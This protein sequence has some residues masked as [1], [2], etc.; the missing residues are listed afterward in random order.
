MAS[1]VSNHIAGWITDH[2]RGHLGLFP[3]LVLNVIALR[4]L[5]NL[6]SDAT[7]DT[8]A[9]WPLSIGV[10]FSLCSFAILVWQIRGGLRS[11]AEAGVGRDLIGWAGYAILLWAVAMF[12][13]TTLDHIAARFTP[14]GYL[15]QTVKNLTVLDGQI[16]LT[17]EISHQTF[18]Q[19][20]QTVATTNAISV[21]LDSP[22]GS[23]FAAR[24]VAKIVQEQSINT[25]S[26]TLCA[27]ACTLIF[28]AGAQRTLGPNGSL[29]FHSYS[30]NTP[31]PLYPSAPEQARDR[32]FLTASGVSAA[33]IERAYATPPDQLWRPTRAELR[34]AGV[35][36]D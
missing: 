2:W 10:L 16:H 31:I 15:V 36:T 3:A 35:L 1:S 5:L 26:D 34:A 25:H 19:F 28:M 22:G 21:L 20:A 30:E 33:F 24:G 8:L 29:G 13:A 27:S 32:A 9:G 12:A 4:L 17:G 23:I 11:I 7:A 14:T 6:T 18:E